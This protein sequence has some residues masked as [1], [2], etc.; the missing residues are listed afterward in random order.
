MAKPLLFRNRN[1]ALVWTS[2][3]ISQL[4]D[5]MFQIA[6]FWWILE[7]GFAN[8][9]LLISTA[10][11]L[12]VL[13]AIVFPKLIAKHVGQF[14]AKKILTTADSVGFLVAFSL[15]A[16]AVQSEQNTP[17]LMAGMVSSFF[18]S[19]CQA[20]ITPSLNTS[21]EKMVDSED[22]ETAV[23]TLGSVTTMAQLAGALFGAALV[24]V[25]GL[26]GVIILNGLT[27]GVSF[28]LDSML[29]AKVETKNPSEQA[30]P[31]TANT[32]SKVLPWGKE[33]PQ[34]KSYVN[35]F[36]GVNLFGAPIVVLIPLYVN[37]VYG[38][39]SQYLAIAEAGVA[40]G[41][42]GGTIFSKIFPFKDSIYHAVTAILF[43]FAAL[44]IVMGFQEIYWLFVF[45]LIGITFVIGVLN[46]RMMSYFQ[47][48]LKP[49][50]KPHFFAQLQAKALVAV[51]LG[52]FIIGG[53]ASIIPYNVI[54]ILQGVFLS[55][56]AFYALSNSGK[57]LSNKQPTTETKAAA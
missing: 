35:L 9:G 25:L 57:F 15:L 4:G 11:V 56:M 2:Q 48:T 31:D 47:V 18:F 46:V 24:G 43:T 20:Y 39:S 16:I 52:Y 54:N 33:F 21:L 5:K 26:Q 50:Q 19:L 23:A 32:E 41:L 45:L 38:L 42:L 29:R 8:D 53:A 13:P 17:I 36:A 49:E 51:P 40:L 7:A 12:A 28:V 34:L 55:L 30:S 44:F 1:V 22:M 14:S 6:F 3:T 10:L 37:K 27:F